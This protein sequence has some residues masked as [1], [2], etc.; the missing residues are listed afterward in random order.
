MRRRDGRCFDANPVNV[1]V[2]CGFYDITDDD[3]RRSTVVEKL[4]S[5]AEGDAAA[6][7]REIDE[8][9]VPPPA[10]GD[11]RFALAAYVALQLTRTPLVRERVMFPIR[12]REYAAGREVT[13]QLVVRYLQEVHLGFMPS[14]PEA[15]AA[16][17]FVSIA[18]RDPEVLTNEF[19]MQSMLHSVEALVPLLLDRSWTVET[20]RKERFLTSDVPVVIWRPPTPRDDFEGIGP[21][22]ADE[23]RFPLAPASQLVLS[24]K[25]RSSAVRVTPARV[26]QCNADLAGACHMFIVGRPDRRAELSAL[27]LRDRRRVLRFNSGPLLKRAENGQLEEDGEV[28]H[29]WVPR[30]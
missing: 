7:L 28:L 27:E 13:I 15:S 22:N 26:R 1:A 14:E 20:D 9:G 11:P 4:L 29:M 17:D 6:V 3:G 30:R 19:A 2:E 12:V 10:G 8:S 23:I 25:P 16:F 21:I 5:Q 18:L 24:L